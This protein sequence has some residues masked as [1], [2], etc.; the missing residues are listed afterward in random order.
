[1]L[2]LPG[3]SLSAEDK[4]I[5]EHPLTGGLIFFTR[6]FE[7]HQQIAELTSEIRS[8]VPK[9]LLFAVDQE[10]GRVQRFR[11]DFTA[12]PS[13]GSILEL[14]QGNMDSAVSYCQAV[15]ELMALEIQSVGIDISFAPV[16]DINDISEV[17]GDRG[18]ASDKSSVVKLVNGFC[19]GMRAA[20]M[21]TTGKHFPGHG[22]VKE[23]SHIALPIDNRE[24]A[25]I[26]D[27]DY[28]VFQQLMS[29]GALDAVMPAHVIYPAFDELPAGFSKVWIQQQ[30]RERL[31][32]KGAVFSDDL[33]MEGAVKSGSP[34]ERAHL[35]IGAG[36]DMALICNSRDTAIEVLDSYQGQPKMSTA[37][38][39][40]I[41]AAPTFKGLTNCQSSERWQTLRAKLDELN[42]H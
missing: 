24:A 37:I 36:C 39:E 25:E 33:T 17:I 26:L 13:M 35:A 28:W 31:Q 5:L 27:K 3:Q 15:A 18:F 14:C 42:E 9:P 4:E 32:F 12:L 22:S 7:D 10:G 41:M 1:M 21:A 16:A 38:A 11:Q 19:Q 30:L 29:Q 8:K 20:G 40:M 23:D 6:N 2:D 34:T